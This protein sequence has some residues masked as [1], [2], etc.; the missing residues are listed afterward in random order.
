MTKPAF[1]PNTKHIFIVE[2]GEIEFNSQ[3]EL[4]RYFRGE[5]PKLELIEGTRY[6]ASYEN[7]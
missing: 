5:K 3:E 7:I 6:K 1:K 4:E 2:N